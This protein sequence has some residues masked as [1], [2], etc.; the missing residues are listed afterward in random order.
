MVGGCTT[1]LAS[2]GLLKSVA[3]GSCG[4]RLA[5]N[6]ASVVSN[7]M[8]HCYGTRG[9]ASMWGPGCVP[10][11]SEHVSMQSKQVHPRRG[12]GL[13]LH[14]TPLGPK[15]SYMLDPSR[16]AK[17]HSVHRGS[18]GAP[19]PPQKKTKRC[20]CCSATT[21]A[22]QLVTCWLTIQTGRLTLHASPCALL[23]AR[24]APK[25]CYLSGRLAGQRRG[26]GW[27]G[28]C[29]S[30]QESSQ[31]NTSGK[32]KPRK[33]RLMAILYS[34]GSLAAVVGSVVNGAAPHAAAQP[35][36]QSLAI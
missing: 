6:L 3:E 10:L 20:R 7:C 21:G 27:A 33:A 16:K 34:Y 23:A 29:Y 13:F 19:P 35:L 9:G 8:P 36:Q 31:L 25:W 5:S 32:P 2:A 4:M 14:A 12:A 22:F 11:C 26:H 24:G 1:W 18:T 15:D 17:D 30:L 28:E